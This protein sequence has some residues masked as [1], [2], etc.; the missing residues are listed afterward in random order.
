MK[1]RLALVTGCTR[2]IGE[3]I[4]A[5]LKSRNLEVWGTGTTTEDP[6]NVDRYITANFTDMREVNSLIRDIQQADIDI[7]IN[8]AGINEVANF[9]DISNQSFNKHQQ[10]NVFVPFKLMQTVAINMQRNNW[11]RIINLGSI[12]TQLGRP[13]RACYASNKHA[14]IGLTQC[15]AAEYSRYNV[16]ANVVSPGIIDTELTRRN[17]NETQLEALLPHI[18]QGRLG[19]VTEVAKYIAWLSTENTFI[20]GQNL[21]IDGGFTIV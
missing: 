14:L 16:L 19:T 5:E 7:L 21:V 3:A 6:G 20:T 17:L 13:G 2:G 10:V 1:P 11:G 18:P 9:G 4:V 15:F 12:W 8:N